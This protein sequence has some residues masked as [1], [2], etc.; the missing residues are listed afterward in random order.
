M[1]G[2]QWKTLTTVLALILMSLPL[3]NARAQSHGILQARV[4]VVSAEPA[5]RVL[6]AARLMAAGRPG[7]VPGVSRGTV[8]LRMLPPSNEKAG[9]R[10]TLQVAYLH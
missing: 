3:R 2:T 8:E 9:G 1:R 4:E 7:E 5:R 10:R 6:R